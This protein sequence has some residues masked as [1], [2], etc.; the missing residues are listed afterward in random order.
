MWCGSIM[1][2][3]RRLDEAVDGRGVGGRTDVGEKEKKK[4]KGGGAETRGE[5]PSRIPSGPCRRW[6]R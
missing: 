2:G 5:E 3:R 4:G 1:E 6:L